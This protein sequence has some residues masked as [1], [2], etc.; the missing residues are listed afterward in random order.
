MTVLL[1]GREGIDISMHDK[2]YHI[3][4]VPWVL[5][6]VQ[7]ALYSALYARDNVLYMVQHFACVGVLYQPEELYPADLKPTTTILMLYTVACS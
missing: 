6:P 5:V 3:Y 1:K 2:K 4:R 7:A